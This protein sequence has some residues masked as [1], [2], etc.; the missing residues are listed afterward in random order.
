MKTIFEVIR[1]LLLITTKKT[2]TFV[3]T[4]GNKRVNKQDVKDLKLETINDKEFIFIQV[5]NGGWHYIE[6]N[7]IVEVL[8]GKTSYYK[9]DNEINDSLKNTEIAETQDISIVDLSNIDNINENEELEKAFNSIKLV[10]GYYL[11]TNIKF[12]KSYD[13][14]FHTFNFNIDENLKSQKFICGSNEDGKMKIIVNSNQLNSFELKRI[15]EYIQ[16]KF[17]EFMEISI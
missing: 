10:S 4:E 8:D 14:N 6:I 12:E 9:F 15:E 2:F 17:D 1:E 3:T 11:P 7:T 16:N 13:G 5:L